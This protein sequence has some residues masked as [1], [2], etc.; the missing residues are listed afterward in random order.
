[1][2]NKTRNERQRSKKQD[3][4]W[5]SILFCTKYTVKQ[6]SFRVTVQ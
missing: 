2:T 6:P 5:Y 3:N 1:M 4:L